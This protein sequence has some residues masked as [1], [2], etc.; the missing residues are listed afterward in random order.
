M[1]NIKRRFYLL[2]LVTTLILGSPV[3]S[4]SA[5]EPTV[6]MVQNCS[7]WGSNGWCHTSADMHI[8]MPGGTVT[9]WPLACDVWAG[10]GIWT[11][12]YTATDN[13][14]GLSTSGSVDLKV[15]TLPPWANIQVPSSTGSNGWFKTTPV[16]IPF[17]AYDYFSGLNTVR[18]SP[19]GGITW[20]TWTQ[21]SFTLLSN[22]TYLTPGLSLSADGQYVIPY[23]VDD[24]SGW[25]RS[26]TGVSVKIDS[27]PPVIT[28]SISGTLGSNGWYISSVNVIASGSD[29]T[30]G[31]ASPGVTVWSGGAWQSSALLTLDGVYP[32]NF[33]A[34]DNAGNLAMVTRTVS[35]DTNPPTINYTVSGTSGSNGWYVSQAVVSATAS[36]FGSGVGTILISDNGGSGKSSPITL[37]DG[38]H[39]L[40]ITATDKAGNS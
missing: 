3:L 23:A 24:V 21:S 2:L 22:G 27:T 7:D 33:R 32:L 30:S 34:T 28:P 35:V 6:T 18:A 31:L 38:I 19:D 12:N 9:C 4:A 15:D 17:N 5:Q 8:S 1:K 14:T 16:V 37:D 40:T 39:N 11:V 20:Q 25:S 26:Y 13:T 29:A 10:N 36:D